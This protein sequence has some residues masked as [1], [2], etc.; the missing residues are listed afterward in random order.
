MHSRITKEKST[1]KYYYTIEVGTKG[2]RKRKVSK[3]F[4]TKREAKEALNSALTKLEQQKL[5]QQNRFPHIKAD[6]TLGE[7]LE[8][9]L[10]MYAAINTAP[11]TYRG[12]A[13][14]IRKI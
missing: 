10:R 4:K 1:G 11:N 8:Y 5:Q 13:Q 6:I 7:Y 12:Y 9:W 2:N 14:I 3:R